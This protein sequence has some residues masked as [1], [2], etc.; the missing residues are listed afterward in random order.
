MNHRNVLVLFAISAF[1]GCGE[2]WEAETYPASG[3]LTI[4]GDPAEGALVQLHAI[5]EPPDERNS[6]PWGKVRSDGTYTLSTYRNEDGAPAGEYA[7]TITWP[8]DSS[9]PSLD[10]R[11]GFTYSD[12]GRSKWK[13][14]IEE[15]ENE[16]PPITL[17]EPTLDH[18]SA[19]RRRPLGPMDVPSATVEGV[20]R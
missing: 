2:S 12:P 13:V 15:G 10:D 14:T 9:V 19:G 5:G 8:P 17:T 11:L 6:R 20:G 7:L 16:L 18:S 1:A 3:R 4:N